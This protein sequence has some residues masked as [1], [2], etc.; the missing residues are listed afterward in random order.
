MDTYLS[1]FVLK[2]F[3]K[4]VLKSSRISIWGKH[5]AISYETEYSENVPSKICGRQSLK[6]SKMY[7][8]LKADHTPSKF[9]NAVFHK[10]YLVGSWI[11]WLICDISNNRR[12]NNKICGKDKVSESAFYYRTVW[13]NKFV[14][15]F[16]FCALVIK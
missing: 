12:Y 8:L 10:F 14:P 5:H 1:P 2:N 15:G 7:G 4:Y 11:L 9:L 16:S 6:N 13:C 3:Q